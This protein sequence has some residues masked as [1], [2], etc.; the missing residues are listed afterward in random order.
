MISHLYQKHQNF[1]KY[2]GIGVLNTVLDKG[3]FLVLFNIAH[4]NE[5]LSSFV[6]LNAGIL[7]SFTLNTLYNYKTNDNIAIRFIQF[8]TINLVGI[9]IT[10]GLIY[11]FSGKV[12]ISANIVNIAA[13]IP[14][15]FVMFFL[16]KMFT[17][18]KLA[19]DQPV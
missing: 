18:K 4:L 17:F 9:G 2:A 1:I 16:N 12:G 6:G 14:V 19:V 10:L 8:Y 5:Y 11:I 7:L 3:L 13:V 15:F